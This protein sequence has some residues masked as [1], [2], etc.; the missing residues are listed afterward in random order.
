MNEIK[1]RNKQ[2][3]NECNT[4]CYYVLF[5][6]LY[7]TVIYTYVYTHTQSVNKHMEGGLAWQVLKIEE[8]L[9]NSMGFNIGDNL[10]DKEIAM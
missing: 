10:Q 5:K 3:K 8:W 9:Q 2:E 7:K 6:N 4:Q 1:I